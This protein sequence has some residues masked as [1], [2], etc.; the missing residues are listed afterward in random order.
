MSNNPL[1]VRVFVTLGDSDI[2]NQR[3]RYPYRLFRKK[4]QKILQNTCSSQRAAKV[5]VSVY[6]WKPSACHG[7]WNIHAQTYT[8]NHLQEAK[9]SSWGKVNVALKR[10]LYRKLGLSIQ[11]NDNPIGEFPSCGKEL[12]EGYQKNT[13][14]HGAAG[15]QPSGFCKNFKN[16]QGEIL[17]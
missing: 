12:R 2:E 17:Y 14:Q 5:R 16:I 9:F 3:K 4:I 8:L 13:K 15:C 11:K 6:V 7:K 1:P 10:R